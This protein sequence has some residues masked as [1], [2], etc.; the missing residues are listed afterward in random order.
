MDSWILLDFHLTRQVKERM[1]G[2]LVQVNVKAF[3]INN[4]CMTR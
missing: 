3:I 1:H 4:T 2:M